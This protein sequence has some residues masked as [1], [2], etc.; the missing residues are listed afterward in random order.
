M[1]L[2]LQRKGGKV[3]EKLLFKKSQRLLRRP[4]GSLKGTPSDNR[5]AYKTTEP[6]YE[7]CSTEETSATQLRAALTVGELWW[8]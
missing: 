3:G 5:S 1:L 4:K 7:V 2:K 8:N 6:S